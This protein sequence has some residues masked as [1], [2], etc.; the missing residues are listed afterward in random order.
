MLF[1][2]LMLFY[3]LASGQTLKEDTTSQSPV[4]APIEKNS[5]IYLVFYVNTS[6]GAPNVTVYDNRSIVIEN[7]ITFSP[8][9]PPL[10]PPPPPPVIPPAPKTQFVILKASGIYNMSN[11]PW[12]LNATGE[13]LESIR[14]NDSSYVSSF[15]GSAYLRFDIENLT[16]DVETIESLSFHV[17]A[18]TGFDAE[19]VTCFISQDGNWSA[20]DVMNFNGINGSAEH[21]FTWDKNPYSGNKWTRQDINDLV[22][23]F[24]LT[25]GFLRINE[26][27]FEVKFTI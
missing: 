13:V 6:S 5:T 16:L 24:S 20:Y 14:D 23:Q 7:P 15:G 22:G 2:S 21:N 11:N 9:L 4:S 19:D 12:N 10:P 17:I 25:S 18:V 27:Y 1:R 3:V 26:V 8:E